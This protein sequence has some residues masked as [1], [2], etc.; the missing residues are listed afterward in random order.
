MEITYKIIEKCAVLSAKN[1][2]NLELNRVQWGENA[3][4]LDIRTWNEDHTKCGKGI[5]LTDE[6]AKVL[7]AALQEKIK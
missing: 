1:K 5:T 6:E 4:K 2:W 3:P 7:I